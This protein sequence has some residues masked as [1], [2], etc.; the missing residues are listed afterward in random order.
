MRDTMCECG[1]G[2]SAHGDRAIDACTGDTETDLPIHEFP[3]VGG[4]M[5]LSCHCQ[6]Y[7]EATWILDRL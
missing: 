5:Y 4:S 3:L 2:F 6:G 1:H 7:R